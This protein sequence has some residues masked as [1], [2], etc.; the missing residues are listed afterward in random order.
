MSGLSAQQD[1]L[2]YIGDP[3][4]SWCYGFAPEIIEIKEKLPKNVV[5]QTVLGGLRPNGTETMADLGDFLKHHWE[6]IESLT[7][8]PFKYDILEQKTFTYNT[9]PACRAVLTA[10]KLNPEQELVFFKAVQTAF[11]KDNKN[12][13]D[14]QTYLDIAKSLNFDTKQF[15]I[16]FNSPELKEATYADFYLSAE[17][18]IRGFPSIVFKKGE[19]LHLISNGYQ[20]AD[21]I[22]NQISL[23][24]SKE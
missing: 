4:C 9:E 14:I 5:F 8:Q 19:K 22:L 10:R 3:M 24:T 15:A 17:M 21:V 18:G 16:Y 6:E 20:K 2:F 12:V 7:G 13:H 23:I 11:Y 1:T